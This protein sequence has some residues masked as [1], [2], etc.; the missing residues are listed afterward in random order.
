MTALRAILLTAAWTLAVIAPVMAWAR[1][2]E[3]AVGAVAGS[4]ALAALA[5]LTA[6]LRRRAGPGGEDR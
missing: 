2:P 5:G 3:V 4:V 6:W 1:R